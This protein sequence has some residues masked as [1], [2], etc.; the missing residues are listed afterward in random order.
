MNVLI[1]GNAEDAHARHLKQALTVAGVRVEYLDTSQFPSE[2]RL[3]WQP[4]TDKGSLTL[5]NGSPFSLSEIHSVFWR[6]F[7]GVGIREMSDANRHRI[8]FNDSMSTVRSLLQ[9]IPARWI[10]SWDAYQF[11]KE[12]PLQLHAVGKLGV[13]I[14]ATLISNDPQQVTAFASINHPVIFKPVYGGAHTQLVSD[15]HLEPERLKAALSLSPV[16]IQA[17]IP[18]TNIRSYAI[19]DEVYT[20]EIRSESLDFRQDPQAQLIPIELP[21]SVRQQ[22]LAIARTLKLAWTAIDWR[23]TQAGEYIFLEA[24]PSPMF[25][26]FEKQ[27]GFPITQKLV[28]LL[29]Q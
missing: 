18:G 4:E 14:P 13:K 29:I 1:L 6:T 5:P 15:R 26:H 7:T 21:E 10:N 11:H 2:L 3:S 17:Y 24:N 25:V 28:E 19:A 16:T 8:A 23:R 9:A 22:C 12:K 20:A 27:T